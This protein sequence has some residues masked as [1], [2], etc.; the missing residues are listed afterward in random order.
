MTE[1]GPWLL[2]VLPVG[3]GLL[4]FIEPCSIGSTLLFIK[5]IEGRESGAKIAQV[6]VFAVAR[7]LFTGSLGLAAVALGAAFVGLQKL[8]WVLLGG[9]YIVIGL[10]FLSGRARVLM[11][12]LGP[13]L[14]RFPGAGGSA[15]L[16]LLF[17]LNIPACA[18]PLLLALLGAVAAGGAAGTAYAA[19]FVSLALFGLA[20]SAPLVAA[21]LF[22]RARV[23]L[24]RLAGLSQRA[25]LWTGALLLALGLWSM[26]T[27]L[28]FELNI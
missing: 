14:S 17:G 19:G 10:L 26:G 5:Y 11:V 25:P 1:L 3:L 12:S 15:L 16:G 21:L 4:G 7:A 23:A 20:L 24:D 2:F 18:A 22:Q 27:A 6:A 8:G 13:R 28:F 9:L